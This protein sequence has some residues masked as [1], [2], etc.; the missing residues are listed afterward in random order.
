MTHTIAE[1][2]QNNRP[3]YWSCGVKEERASVIAKMRPAPDVVEQYRADFGY[4]GPMLCS[5]VVKARAQAALQAQ[6]VNRTTLTIT[7][8]TNVHHPRRSRRVV[9]CCLLKCVTALHCLY[10]NC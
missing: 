3:P 5:H 1:E 6:T 4:L 10:R 2:P 8:V 7:Q 9:L